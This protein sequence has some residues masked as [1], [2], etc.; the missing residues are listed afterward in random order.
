MIVCQYICVHVNLP[1][2]CSML[3]MCTSFLGVFE[4]SYSQMIL[5]IISNCYRYVT[6]ATHAE[7]Y[8]HFFD[9]YTPS[10]ISS[11]LNE[12]TVTRLYNICMHVDTTVMHM[13]IYSASKPSRHYIILINDINYLL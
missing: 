10:C 9:Q 13:Y 6:M 1:V 11:T 2:V 8:L 7:V 3:F 4:T 12:S 5:Q